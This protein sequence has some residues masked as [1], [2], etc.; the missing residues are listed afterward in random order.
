[1]EAITRGK[2]AAAFSFRFSSSLMPQ[3]N[4]SGHTSFLKR[5][6]SSPIKQVSVTF[7]MLGKVSNCRY[8]G[9][10]MSEIPT[11]P[12]VAIFS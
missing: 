5:R 3:F 4:M 1:M 6:F 9:K 7:I 11:Y 2:S 8:F 12:E 10:I